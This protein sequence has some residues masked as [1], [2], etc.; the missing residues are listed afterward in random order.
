MRKKMFHSTFAPTEQ[1]GF[2]TRFKSFDGLMGVRLTGGEVSEGDAEIFKETSL[3][4]KF[5][6]Y[7]VPEVLPS[8]SLRK[9]GL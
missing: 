3:R 4:R 1:P 8:V 9:R 7:Q 6:S 2:Q 5:K